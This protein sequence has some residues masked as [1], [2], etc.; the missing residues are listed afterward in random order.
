MLQKI[1]LIEGLLGVDGNINFSNKEFRKDKII[2]HGSYFGGEEPEVCK[3]TIEKDHLEK[4]HKAK[5][6]TDVLYVYEYIGY[7][8][9]Y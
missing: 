3:F 5:T 4:L 8:I 1:K 9:N 2:L 7:F 6:V